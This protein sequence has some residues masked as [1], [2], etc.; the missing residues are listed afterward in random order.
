[1]FRINS[2]IYSIVQWLAEV[3]ADWRI[4]SIVATILYNNAQGVA[5][6]TPMG[7]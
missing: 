7:Y 4:I 6:T 2:L 5:M 3:E 1:M